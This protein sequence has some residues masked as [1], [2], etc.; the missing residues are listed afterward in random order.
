MIIIQRHEGPAVI[1]GLLWNGDVMIIQLMLGGINI[2]IISEKE[3]PVSERMQAFERQYGK[4]DLN[5]RITW[6][7]ENARH[8]KSPA[9]GEDLIQEYYREKDWRFCEAKGGK[10]PITCTCYKEDLSQMVC[11]VN[12]RPFLQ[13]PDTFDKIIRLLPMRE[14]FQHFHTIFLHASQVVLDGTGIVFSAASGTGKSTQAKLWERYE[15]AEIV[16][17]DRTLLQKKADEWKTY[18]YPMDGSEPIGNPDVHKLGCIV[19]LHQSKENSVKRLKA[20]QAV[21][22][23]M[24]QTIIDCWDEKAAMKEMELL[25]ELIEQIPIYQLQCTPDERAVDVL[26]EVLIRDGVLNHV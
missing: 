12:E 3:L 14:I 21:A 6:D 24:E 22:L 9:I 17:S 26:M 7:W 4:V 11:A 2:D 18:G 25:L 13:P 20:V 23:L 5:I 10:A 1:A 15:R 8:P 19:L 16:C